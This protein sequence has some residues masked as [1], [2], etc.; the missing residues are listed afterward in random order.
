MKKL[1]LMVIAMHI[2]FSS[3]DTSSV[4]KANKVNSK[5]T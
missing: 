2:D 1:Q 4:I 5:V 3:T